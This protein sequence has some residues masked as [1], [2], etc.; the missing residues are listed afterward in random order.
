MRVIGWDVETPAIEPGNLT[1]PLVVA[2]FAGGP[3][4]LGLTQVATDNG[5]APGCYFQGYG[6]SGAVPEEGHWKLALKGDAVLDF[7]VTVINALVDGELDVLVAHNGSFDW[8]VLCNEWPWLLPVMTNLM[9]AGKIRDTMVREKLICIRDDNFNFDSRRGNTATRYGLDYLVMTYLRKD[10]SADK[11]DPNSWRLRYGELMDVPLNEWP[12]KALDYALEDAVYARE[13]FFKQ[14]PEVVDELPQTAAAWALHLMA[15]HG[16]YTDADYVKAFEREVTKQAEEANQA[17]IEAG[18]WKVNRC[19]YCEGTGRTLGDVCHY[20]AGEEHEVAVANG[21]YKS[22]AKH[23]PGKHM[24]RLYAL[25]TEAYHGHPPLTDKGSVKTDADTLLGSGHPLLI[26]YAEGAQAQKLLN[27]YLPILERGI[28]HPITSSPNVLVRSGRTSWRNPNFQNPPQRGGF[29]E[30]FIPRKGKAFASIDYTGLEMTTLG[31]VC[32]HYFGYS[33]IAE[34]INAGQ[35][36]HTL[37][38][39]YMLQKEGHGWADYETCNAIRKDPEH[40]HYK[41]VKER[42]QNAK[43]ANFGFPGGLGVATLV[44]Y[45]KGMGVNL[46]FNQADE[47]KKMWMEMWPEMVDYFNMISEA[48]NMSIDGRFTVT[49]LYSGR[50]RGGCSFTSGANTYFQGLA[51]DGAKAAMWALYKACYLGELPEYMAG[52]EC[53]LTGVRM[54]AFIHDEFLF[55]GSEDRAHLWAPQASRIMVEEMKKYTPDVK[56]A[57]PPA[58][59]RR[60]LK[61]AEPAYEGGKLVP[62]APKEA[63]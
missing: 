49:Q 17:A 60:W 24:K 15:C 38:A 20:C 1:P 19:K 29:R 50:V 30:C 51:A 63:E 58:L 48:A 16:V 57:A 46:T 44:D 42:R 3:D 54:W 22:R 23:K 27:T 52:E 37:F 53:H 45:A 13:V 26:K 47:L 56:Q 11:K 34:A 25:V 8:G 36:L 61:N 21:R 43:V 33:R 62:W 14:G 40:E 6:G 5:T 2:T 18:F 41:L 32:L 39:A 10:I 12:S 55:E 35:D 59:M 7:L 31:Q 4:T 28:Y 9:E